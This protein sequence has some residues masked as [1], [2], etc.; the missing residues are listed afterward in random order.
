MNVGELKKLI[1]GV[2][3]DVLILMSGSDHSLRE[4]GATYSTV[5]QEGRRKFM[6]DYGEEMTPEAEYGKRIHALLIA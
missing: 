1:D 6:E 4:A 5:L 2:G 3:D